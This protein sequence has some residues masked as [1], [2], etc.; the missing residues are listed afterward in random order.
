MAHPPLEPM[1]GRRDAIRGRSRHRCLVRPELATPCRPQSLERRP[2]LDLVTPCHRHC[3]HVVLPSAWRP[4]RPGSRDGRHSHIHPDTLVA[5][6]RRDAG[7][8]YKPR[9]DAVGCLRR[10]ATGDPVQ[11]ISPPDRPSRDIHGTPTR[12]RVAS[13]SLPVLV[14]HW[15]CGAA[16]SWT[17]Q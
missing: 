5:R 6:P 7:R 13:R 9:L 3:R 8:T 14:D 17:R 12:Q 10:P 2:D 11:T 1:A 4:R 15:W 16:R